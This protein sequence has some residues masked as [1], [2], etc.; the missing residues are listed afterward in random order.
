VLYQWILILQVENEWYSEIVIPPYHEFK[1]RITS[2]NK[3]I[4]TP[5]AQSC[6]DTELRFEDQM[7]SDVAEICARDT[8][9][10]SSTTYDNM[11]EML[12]TIT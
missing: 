3:D 9:T 10:P 12:N 4:M 5:A 11:T 6:T 8:S 1:R 7:G 2:S